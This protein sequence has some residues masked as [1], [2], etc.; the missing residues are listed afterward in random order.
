MVYPT[1]HLEAIS[2]HNLQVYHFRKLN[3]AYLAGIHG[4]LK[5]DSN[6]CTKNSNSWV[7]AE[8]LPYSLTDFSR[9]LSPKETISLLQVL[10]AGYRLMSYIF[11]P[12]IATE[13]RIFFTEIGVP[14]VWAN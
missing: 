3:R 14:K 9:K 2:E 13:E 1:Q 5:E 12:L 8:H 7:L 10:L 11:G 6:I 4:I